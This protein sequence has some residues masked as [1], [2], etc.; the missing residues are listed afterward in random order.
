MGYNVWLHKYVVFLTA[1]LFAGIS[2]ILY[3]HFYGVI[4]PRDIGVMASGTPWLMLIIGGPGTLWGSL[5]GSGIV[6]SL[7]YFISL[8][9]AQR[10]PLILGVLYIAVVM[11]AR[12]GILVWVSDLIKKRGR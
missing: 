2:G 7:Q 6:L 12:K 3:V 5:I 10:W 8:V 11:T 1:G 4:V 9:T